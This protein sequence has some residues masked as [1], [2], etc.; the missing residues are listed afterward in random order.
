MQRLSLLITFIFVLK[1]TL[2]HAQ[3]EGWTSAC[4]QDDPSVSEVMIDACSN[5]F[6]SE[7]VVLK[8][9]NKPFDVRN[10]GMNV[11]NPTNNAFVGSASV[12]N[13]NLNANALRLLNEAA[14][15]VCGY[16]TVFRDVFQAPY[17][18]VVPPNSTI[19]FFNNKD[20][21]DVSYLS[22]NELRRL[23]GSKVFTVFGTINPQSPNVSLFRNYPQNGSCGTTGCLR[24]IQFRFGGAASPYCTQLTYDI[25]KLPNLNST[26]PPPGFN[27]GSYIRPNPN[28]SLIYGGGNLTGAGVVCMPPEK[29]LCTIPTMPDYGDGFWNVLAYDNFNDF[30]NGSFKGFYQAKGNHTVSIG[31]ATADNFEFNTVRDGWGGTQG[32]SEAHELLGA[33]T[34]YNGCNTRADSFSIL[35]KRKGFDCGFYE[36]NLNYYD[37]FTRMRIDNNGDGVWDFDQSNNAPTCATGCG[38]SIWQGFLS[39]QSKIE[40]YAYDMRGNFNVHFLF[41]KKP[42][43]PSVKIN[44]LSTTPVVCGGLPTGSITTSVTGGITPYN[45]TWTGATAI[46]NGS[47]VATNLPAGL[48]QM[49]ATD[50]VGCTDSA[51]IL[52]PQINNIAI[53]AT[54]DTAFCPGGTAILRG[55]A[56]GGTGALTAEWLTTKSPTVLSTS[57]NYSPIVS[58]SRNYVL[59]VTDASGCFK[60]DTVAVNVH[61]LPIIHVAY[62]PNDTVCNDAVPVLR[63]SGA[64]SY[65]WS[66]F[67][68]I[69]AAALDA[70]GDSARLF[71]LFLPA[72]YYIFTATGTDGNGC[73]NTGQAIITIIPLPVV[74]IMPVLDSL[75]NNGAPRALTVTPVTGGTF[76]VYTITP[77]AAIPCINCVENNIFY[78][79]RAGAGTHLVS[80]QVTNAQGCTNAPS[81]QVHVKSCRCLTPITTPL[82][83]SICSGDSFRVKTIF[84]KTAGI[85]RDTFRN[86]FCDSIV[87]LNLTLNKRDTTYLF[88]K[89][90]NAAQVGTTSQVLRNQYGCDSLVVLNLT[91]SKSDTT[92][93]FA[94]TCNAAQVGTTSQ[95]LRNQYGC[96]SLVVL[97]LTYSKSD[98]TNLFGKTCNAAQVGTTSQVLRN[99]YGCDSLVILN[100]TYSKSDTTNIFAKTCNA[101][102]VGTTSQ[103]LRNQYGCDSLVVLNLTYSKSDT[104]NLFAKT[105][106]AA[107]VGTTSQLLRN[108]YGCDSLV[109]LNLTYNKGD[110]THVSAKTCNP[111]Q[112]GTT[113]QLLRNQYGCDSLII[114]TK[115]F[116]RHDTTRYTYVI[117]TGDSVFVNNIWIK[118]GGETRFNLKN[119]EG[120]DSIVIANIAFTKKDTTYQTA[121]SCDITRIGLDTLRRINRNGCDSLI[122][123]RTTFS[124][125]DSTRFRLTT[126]NPALVGDDIQVFKNRL[127]CD[128]V[129]I[130]TYVLQKADTTYSF[131]KTCNPVDTGIKQ[132][133]LSNRDGCDSIVFFRTTLSRRDSTRFN[134]LICEG[135]SLAF[136]GRWIKTKGTYFDTLTNTEG[137]D[138][139]LVLTLDFWKK[140]TTFVQKT[141]CNPLL[142]GD[143]VKIL[144]GYRGCDSIIITQTRLVPSNMQNSLIVSKSISCNGLA[145]GA[146]T[147]KI[148]SG[149]MSPFNFNWSNGIKGSSLSN[150]KAGSYTVTVTDAEGCLLID[151]IILQNPPTLSINVVGVSPLCFG[152]EMGSMRII[153]VGGGTAPYR[154]SSNVV[155][156]NLTTFP[157]VLSNIRLGNYAFKLTDAA[158]C[159]LDSTLTVSPALEHKIDV[160]ADITIQ[161]GDSTQIGAFLNFTKARYKWTA[162]GG[163]IRCDTCVSTVVSPLETTVYRLMAKDEFGCEVND[164]L[165]VF[166]DKNRPIFIPTSFSPNDDGVNDRFTVFSDTKVRKVQT[167]KI[168]N[169]WGTPVFV[170]NDFLP[171]D[172]NQ[173]WDGTAR[174]VVLQPDVYVYFVRIEFVDG[175]VYQYQGDVTII[176]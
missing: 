88:A 47:L 86:T 35:A 72:P 81:I 15:T 131:S 125:S 50:G 36:I 121:T 64:Q 83:K 117:C 10:L 106:N 21:T 11:I 20:S 157:T 9:G 5:E 126:C 31:T 25:K 170:Q 23:C 141:S 59:R 13:N 139:V 174:G 92:N 46:P 168:F 67:P 48:F 8:T 153:F 85:Y 82:S 108:Q 176:K 114:T 37:D 107:Q 122:I 124:V 24:Q 132:L 39:P 73:K 95:T 152:D 27:E 130:K 148:N 6:R 76:I 166:V 62:S 146:L 33:L 162:S 22:P 79:D 80:Y 97:N 156:Q 171:N 111:S 99:Q 110:T 68:P 18:G 2:S 12:Q 133:N 103:V 93:I 57:L 41:Q 14:G 158:G 128:S 151:S 52:V 51:Q 32:P 45:I 159:I 116:G 61:P 135:D 90:C 123:T 63:A 96:D 134:L 175:K 3:T 19:L 149:G 137:C 4:S 120:C 150:L 143:S 49:K 40:I 30:S 142:V 17:N 65:I 94:K 165:T 55:T 60:T 115:T 173:G 74:T 34:T 129:V 163:H 28:G 91:Y 44:V 127:G 155:S 112:V 167:M 138:S 144:R 100:L 16:G 38:T 69:G 98:T 160:G 109:V 78:P 136:T 145:D 104:T 102:Q 7:Y 84:Y 172:E 164:A 54:A 58:K 89:T 77:T 87:V 140:D 1:I 66:S 169:R 70:R 119:N 43:P 42:T 113:S 161:L 56:S 154:F 26:N 105:C 29:L 71:S 75:C 53:N 118:T 101:A 147:I